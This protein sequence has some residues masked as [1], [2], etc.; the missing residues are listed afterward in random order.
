MPKPYPTVTHSLPYEMLFIIVI[1]IS[2]YKVDFFINFYNYRKLIN[3][4]LP[5]KLE[6]N[7]DTKRFANSLI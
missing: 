5:R 4:N 6:K 3:V 7:S 1:I 2:F